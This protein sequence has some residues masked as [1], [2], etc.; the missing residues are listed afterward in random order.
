MRRLLLALA[1]ATACS[2]SGADPVQFVTEPFEPTPIRITLDQLPA[3]NATE[4]A[5][6]SPQMV[7]P[8]ARAVFR[9]P[10]GFTVSLYADRIEKPRWLAVTPE[11]DVVV[12]E[13]RQN[14]I[15]RIRDTD[16]DGMPE[17]MAVFGDQ[18]NGLNAP[19]GMAF[20]DT[21]FYLGNT[22]GVLRFPYRKGQRL[23]GR[24]QKVTDLTPGGYN[25]HW[26]RNV[27]VAPD[28][29]RL[30]VTVGSRSNNDVEEPPRASVL[31]MNLDGSGR[32]TFAD[33]LRNP[34][35]LDFHPRTGEVYVAVN[36]RDRLGDDLVP[37]YV[38]RVRH[39]EF[40]GWPWAYLSPKHLDPTH[41]VDG[42]STN[43]DAV[44]RTVT[45][46]VLIEAH[47]AA[48]GLAFYRG[49]AFPPKY[50]DGA[51]VACRGSWNRT[52]GTGYKIVFVPFGDDGRPLGHYED[53]V[54]GFLVDPSGPTTWGRPVGIVVLPDGSLL[55]ADEENERLY[56]VTYGRA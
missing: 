44:A 15:Q 51:F 55:F 16:G 26:T 20:T 39:R 23:E 14:R 41:V 25:Q 1:C 5:R 31:R 13:T 2:Q 3:P 32:E 21:H 9:A 4:S 50:R 12:T 34:V 38:T 40:F 8:P 18:S 11:G 49:D 52:Q 7:D 43:P 17:Q 10:A 28:G 33:G 24:G 56:R 30:F 27:R 45:P 19:F 46:D 37:D 36:E 48:L 22:D 53:F 54:T 6:K 35:G 47:S 29:Q 42:R